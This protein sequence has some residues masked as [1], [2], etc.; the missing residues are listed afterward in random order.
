VPALRDGRRHRVGADRHRTPAA[1][2]RASKHTRKSSAS[3][4]ATFGS[5]STVSAYTPDASSVNVLPWR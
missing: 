1:D 3:M 5:P 2:Q 4:A